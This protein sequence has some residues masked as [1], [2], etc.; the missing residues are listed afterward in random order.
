MQ[1]GVVTGLDQAAA[2]AAAGA[3]YCE[4]NVQ[5]VFK[6]ME[7]DASAWDAAAVTNA[8][9][10]SYASCCF[11]PGNLKSTGPDFDL[12]GILAYAERAFAR[13]ASVNCTTMVFG[14]GGS[15]QVPEGFSHDEARG[16]LLEALRALG[17]LAA[18]HGIMMVLE[19]LN[20]SEC[21][22]VNSVPEGAAIVREVN[23]PN[24]RLLADFYHM[25]KDGQPASDLHGNMDIIEHLHLAEPADRTPLGVAGDDFRPYLAEALAAGYLGRISVEC[26][27]TDLP[28][29]IDTCLAEL[30]RQLAEAV[31]AGS[32]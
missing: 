5:G 20:A 21:N 24:I 6:P 31:P 19:P 28:A 15:R 30:R 13:A 4:V 16:Q 9:V 26:R 14:S 1:I 7:A 27:W 12:P 8:A 18:K 25:M 22:I 32:R 23:H 11:L 29:Q 10:S 17:P 2:L 3:D